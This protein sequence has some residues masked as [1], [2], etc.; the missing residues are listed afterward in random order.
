MI[1]LPTDECINIR[2][3]SSD[4]QYELYSIVSGVSIVD[5]KKAFK[6]FEDNLAALMSRPFFCILYARFKAEP[7]SWAKTE[8]DLVTALIEDSLDE[9]S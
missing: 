3:L 6:G 8:M 1:I 4:A 7:R 2:P 5:A 9:T